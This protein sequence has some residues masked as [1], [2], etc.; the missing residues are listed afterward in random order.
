MAG[1][2]KRVSVTPERLAKIEATVDWSRVNAMTDEMVDAARRDD[3]ETLPPMTEAEIAAAKAVTV[4]RARAATG[5]S[6]AAFAFRFR[7]PP[8]TV[9]DWEQARRSPDAAALAY[10]RVIEREP[11]VVLRALGAG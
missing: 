5:L 10:L 3:P 11:E 1:Q 8:G 7:I 9:Q 4:R 6:Q 2:V